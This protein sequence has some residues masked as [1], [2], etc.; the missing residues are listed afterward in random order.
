[1][2]IYCSY[3]L[4]FVAFLAVSVF[5]FVFIK[6]FFVEFF[7]LVSLLYFSSFILYCSIFF[8]FF[9]KQKTAYDMRICYW[10]SD[11]CSSDLWRAPSLS[12]MSFSFMSCTR[13]RF[14][15]AGA[16]GGS[17]DGPGHLFNDRRTTLSRRRFT[18]PS[19]FDAD[20]M[21]H[22]ADHAAHLGGV[23]KLDR[24]VH[25]APAGALERRKLILAAADRRPGLGHLHRCG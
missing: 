24:L 3:K 15:R 12:R 17:Q 14:C 9:F 6:L 2:C 23:A 20:H 10:S 8:F 4:R 1:M 18:L 25:L 22:L 19:A 16:A 7:L 21:L 11:L 5:V 13:F